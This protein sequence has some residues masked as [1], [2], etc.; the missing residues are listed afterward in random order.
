MK[1]SWHGTYDLPARAAISAISLD[2][3][4]L[5]SLIGSVEDS[6]INVVQRQETNSPQSVNHRPLAASRSFQGIHKA[7][8]I[9]TRIPL[10]LFHIYTDGAKAMAGKSADAIACMETVAPSCTSVIIPVTASTPGVGRHFHLTMSFIK[11]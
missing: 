5:L 4:S 2:A 10:D 8:A 11:Q 3:H 6:M 7:K 9:F 1:S